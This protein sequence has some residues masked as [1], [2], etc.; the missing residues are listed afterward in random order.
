MRQWIGVLVVAVLGVGCTSSLGAD[1]GDQIDEGIRAAKR[2]Y[3]QEAHFRFQ[4]ASEIDPAN[5]GVLNNLAVTLEALGRYDE[6]RETYERA[7]A[8]PGSDRNA[9]RNLA[10]FNEFYDT[11]VETMDVPEGAS[12]VP[13]E[14]AADPAAGAD[15]DEEANDA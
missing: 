1:F 15:E 13:P 4:R 7:I 11:Y 12:P 6:A 2:G 8:A 9:Q 10:R 5:A 3:W 14:D